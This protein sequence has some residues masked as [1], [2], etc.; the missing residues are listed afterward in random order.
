MYISAKENPV[1][2]TIILLIAEDFPIALQ[3]HIKLAYLKQDKLTEPYAAGKI[4]EFNQY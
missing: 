3:T 1:K 2:N 4:K